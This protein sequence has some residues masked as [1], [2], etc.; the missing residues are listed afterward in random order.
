MLVPLDRP[1][2]AWRVSIA[3]AA[4]LLAHRMAIVMLVPQ[5]LRALGPGLPSDRPVVRRALL[6][7][8]G[9]AVALG[10]A[11]A[12][13]EGVGPLLVR[14]VTELLRSLRGHGRRGRSTCSA[15]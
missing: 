15:R 10:I 12:L 13:A 7:L 11:L 4:L 14:D 2:R 5:P 3:F 9:L 8:T 1:A 6:G